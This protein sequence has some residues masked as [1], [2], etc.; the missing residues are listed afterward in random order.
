[1]A[2]LTHILTVR[3]KDGSALT[4]FPFDRGQPCTR[5][6]VYGKAD[7]DARLADARTRPDLEVIVR[8][9]TDADRHP[10]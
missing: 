5:I 8:L 2:R 10:A 9:A 7:L 4:G 1:M 3:T 6:A